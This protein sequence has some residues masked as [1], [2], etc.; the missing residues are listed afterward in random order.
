MK[1][2]RCFI[3]LIAGIL[4]FCGCSKRLASRSEGI[5]GIGAFAE[6]S[7]YSASHRGAPNYDK[8]LIAVGHRIVIEVPESKLVATGLSTRVEGA[9]LLT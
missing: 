7:T 8:R 4:L 5:A 2:I 1:R 3:L 9:Y 6:S